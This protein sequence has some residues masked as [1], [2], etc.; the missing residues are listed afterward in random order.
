M[1]QTPS[2]LMTPKRSALA[3]FFTWAAG[4]GRG[5]PRIIRAICRLEGGQLRS[6]TFRE[7]MS[8]YYGIVIGLH[9]YGPCLLP[10]HLPVGTKV[11]SYCSLAAGILVF[12]RNHPFRRAAQHPFFYNSL[13]GMLERDS[14]GADHEN[15]LVIGSDV[16]IGANAII[17]PGCR[18][19]GLGA[20][21]GSG[22]V[23]TKD[24]P[25]FTIVG[26]NP[27]RQIGE[28]FP[29]TLQQ[30]LTESKWWEHP[31]ERLHP[32][33]DIF[34]QD[35]SAENSERLMKHLRAFPPVG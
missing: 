35:A 29:S 18:S 1:A 17:T 30:M 10:G 34:L 22:A 16:W 8:R 25:P 19:I 15:P 21:V 7:L 5:R 26:G 11:G 13:L 9:S 31:I 23:V 20:V 33:L 28:R 3:P 27:A 14:I 2:Q 4:F 12:R 24:V 6:V 32:H